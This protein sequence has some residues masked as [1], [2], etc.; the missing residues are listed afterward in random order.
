[1]RH[2]LLCD[3]EFVSSV[4]FA[5]IFSLK[6]FRKNKLCPHCLHQFE[7]L[8][9]N[10]C[11]ICSRML[12]QGFICDDCKKWQKIYQGEV[13]HN[14]ALYRY[15]SAFHDLMVA[16]KRR[17]DYVLREVLQELS[18]D[19]LTK[20]IFDCYIPVPTSPEHQARRQFDTIST[21]YGDIVPLT[22][23]LIKKEGS[24]AQ[25]E[26]NKNERL[27]TPQSF[28]INKTIKIPGNIQTGKVLLLDDIYTT[29][30][31]LYHARDCLKARFPGMHIESFSI[32]R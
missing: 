14:H 9:G 2:C 32:C 20:T 21:I 27:K 1:M 15:N 28:F 12:Q 26:K 22:P 31:T 11:S 18:W 4:L 23:L 5:Q 6:S 30:R 29:G 25:G 10:R 8:T 24:H 19:Y 16:Y 13:L 3:Q 17:G 7:K